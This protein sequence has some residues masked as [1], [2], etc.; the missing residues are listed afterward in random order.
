ME[1]TSNFK[2]H[3]LLAMPQL[4]D[5]WFS[6]CVCY[7]CD[8]DE[9]GSMGLVINK[10]LN[11]ELGEIL[12]ELD[13]DDSNAPKLPVLQGGPVSP[14]QG[15]VLY[16]GEDSDMQNMQIAGNVHLTTSKDILQNIAD[17]TGPQSVIVCLGYAGWEAGQL[18]AEIAANS[19]LTIPA[20]EE[21]LFHTPLQELAQSAAKKLGVDLNLI[22]G[23]SGHA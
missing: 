10:P 5:P 14:E 17:G 21:L 13:I 2:H 8:H 18:E 20:D 16:K 1:D 23:Q 7:I 15:F 19:W 4:S 3:F 22:T 12:S 9:H 6:R 11:M